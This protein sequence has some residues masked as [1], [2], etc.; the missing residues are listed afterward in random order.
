[1]TKESNDIDLMNAIIG[2]SNSEPQ[3]DPAADVNDSGDKPKEPENP[4]GEPP[5]EPTEPSEPPTESPEDDRDKLITNLSAQIEELKHQISS[6]KS[7]QQPTEEP[8]SVPKLEDEQF[9]SDDDLVDLTENTT[10]FNQVLNK[11]YQQLAT[12]L[13]ES[14]TEATLRSIPNI[15]KSNIVTMTALQRAADSFYDSNPDLKPFK[16]VVASV[17]EE[18]SG[19]NPG[20]DYGEILD[21]LAPEVR[22]RLNLQPTKNKPKAPR[23]PS[24][25]TSTARPTEPSGPSGLEAELEAMNKALGA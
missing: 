3:E 7:Q 17:F 2:G 11:V 13:H 10:K 22:K 5:A 24:K 18:L 23:L 14:V 16:K 1:M 4:T 15:V 20:K 25:S 6:L 8:P 9:I 21:Q 12:K 19:Q